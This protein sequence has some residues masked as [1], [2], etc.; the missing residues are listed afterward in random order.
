MKLTVDEIARIVNGSV[1]GDSKILIEGITNIENP[2]INHI[3]F[4]QDEKL[5]KP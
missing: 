1:T 3:T 4:V 2:L 5:Q